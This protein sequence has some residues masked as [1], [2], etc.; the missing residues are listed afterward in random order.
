MPLLVRGFA[1]VFGN[2]DSYGEVVDKGAFTK[3]IAKN[4]ETSLPLFWQHAHKW[5]LLAKPIGSTT[6]LKQTARGLYYEASIADTPEGLEVQELI[7]SGAVKAASFAYKTVT[8]EVRKNTLHL[9]DLDLIE[10]TAANW[11]AN[12]RAYIEPIPGQETPDE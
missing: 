12:D 6:M 4:P 10:I 11:G 3:W 9:V 1:S 5:N 2:K 7:R 8:E